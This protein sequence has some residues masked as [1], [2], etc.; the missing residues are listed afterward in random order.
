[1]IENGEKVGIEMTEYLKDLDDEDLMLYMA[2]LIWKLR[3]E[4]INTLS[5]MPKM[6][7]EVK[8][9]IFK[10]H[11][12]NYS[13]FNILCAVLQRKFPEIYSE[14]GKSLKQMFDESNDKLKGVFQRK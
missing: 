12:C 6:S 10:H 3:G 1:M 8:D 2:V 14:K 7:D 11:L 9:N 4:I 13:P 5:L